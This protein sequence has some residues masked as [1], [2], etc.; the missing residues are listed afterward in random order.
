MTSLALIQARHVSFCPDG[1][2]NIPDHSHTQIKES[3]ALIQAQ[4]IAFYP[5]G[6]INISYHFMLLQ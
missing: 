6:E 2:S 4:H 5:D 3:L 1:E